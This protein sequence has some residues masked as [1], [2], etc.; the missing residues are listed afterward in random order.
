SRGAGTPSRWPARPPGGPPARLRLARR[1]AR[2]RAG[3]GA[4]RRR[5]AAGGGSLQEQGELEGEADAAGGCGV[6][7]QLAV[8]ADRQEGG[9]AQQ[10]RRR[11][12]RLRRLAP[13]GRHRVAVDGG[14]VRGDADAHRREEVAGVEGDA[15][16]DRV[17]G[18][19]ELEPAT[20][21]RPAEEEA[22]EQE[23]GPPEA[24]RQ[25]GRVHSGCSTFTRWPPYSIRAQPFF[26]ARSTSPACTPFGSGNTHL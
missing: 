25:D 11:I 6:G 8:Q 20:L 15:G 26:T 17:G 13:A 2:P 4:P 3:G 23:E 14:H 9:A 22:R 24:G 21:G 12:L 16:R 18:H 10:Q 19:H 1:A 5:G 7:E